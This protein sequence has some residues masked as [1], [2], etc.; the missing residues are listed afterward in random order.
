MLTGTDVRNVT[1]FICQK[2][3]QQYDILWIIHKGLNKADQERLGCVG[4][5]LS[6]ICSVLL[7]K[8]S[9]YFYL[10][11]SWFICVTST[12]SLNLVSVLQACI[13]ISYCFNWFSTSWKLEELGKTPLPLQLVLVYQR[14]VWLREQ[15][16][17]SFWTNTEVQDPAKDIICNSGT[18]H[19]KIPYERYF[20]KTFPES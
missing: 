7:Y 10:L 9:V 6:E 2:K 3:R 20:G 19:R 18:R 11:I 17:V 5:H 1:F 16:F 12:E 4:S 13:C 15:L 8:L 14:W